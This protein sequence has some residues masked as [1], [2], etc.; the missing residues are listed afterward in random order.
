MCTKNGHDLESCAD[1]VIVDVIEGNH[2]SQFE[3]GER[4]VYAC[5]LPGIQAELSGEVDS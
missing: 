1:I 4:C 2:Q 5:D 3:G